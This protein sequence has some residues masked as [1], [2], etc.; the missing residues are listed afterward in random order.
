M[1]A[2]LVGGGLASL[3][4][5][6]Y[7]IRDGGLLGKDISVYEARA[8]LG[9]SLSVSGN[10][11]TGYVYPGGRVFEWQYRC[12]MDL[13]SM[14]PSSSDPSKSIKQEI[15]EFNEQRSW[16]DKARLVDHDARIVA[17]H[18]LELSLRH[19]I[20]LAKLVLTPESLLDEKQIKDCVSPNFFETNFWYIWSSIMAFVP[21]HSALE[22]R[23]YIIRFLHLLPDLSTMTFILRTRYNQY[24]AIVEPLVKWLGG[25][26]VNFATDTFVSSIDFEP[27]LGRITANALEC[28][29]EGVRTAVAVGEDDLVMITNGSQL[30]DMS[31]GSMDSPPRP[32]TDGTRNSWALWKTLARGRDDFGRPEVFTDHIDRSRWVSFT[33]TCTNAHFVRLMEEF[34]GREAGRGG[35]MTFKRSNWLLTVVRFHQPNVIGQ[36]EGTFVGWGYGIYPERDGN[37]IRK[38]MTECTGA[39]ILREALAHLGLESQADPIVRSSICIPCLLPFVSSVCLVRKKS[40]RP[41]VVPKGSTNFAFI[42]QFCEQP[43]DVIFTMEYS[44]RS[45]WTAVHTLLKTDRKPPPVYRG[46]YSPRI[47]FR[48]LKALH[49]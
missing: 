22:M 33:V 9:G 24:Q 26:G 43:D 41:L 46:Y 28:I 13:F 14:V 47:L 4:A 19:K 5:A 3:A 45:A 35:L 6:A 12:A 10:A 17:S 30:A 11:E 42:G 34:T 21:E 23:R 48:V 39:E 49:A 40:D 2:Y 29:K 20:Q 31:V 25:Q 37:F 27:T 44:V 38:P 1:K 7:L 18:H 8:R 15:A 16:Y 32:R 36:P